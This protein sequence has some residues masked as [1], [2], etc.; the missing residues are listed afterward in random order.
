VLGYVDVCWR[1]H[2]QPPC[3][4]LLQLGVFGNYDSK[5]RELSGCLTRSEQLSH[6]ERNERVARVGKVVRVV[7]PE[8]TEDPGVC[9]VRTYVLTGPVYVSGG[10]PEDEAWRAGNSLTP[11]ELPR[12]IEPRREK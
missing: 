2:R 1:A 4:N 12:A 11:H 3:H 9:A 8:E 6:A 10:P 5:R 7:K